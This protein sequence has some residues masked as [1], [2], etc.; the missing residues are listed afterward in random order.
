MSLIKAIKAQL[1]ISATASQNFTLTAEAADG[2]MKLARGNAG[3][4]TQDILAVTSAGAVKLPQNLV[5]FDAYSSV[6]QTVTTATPTK[7]TFNIEVY[8]TAS[9]FDNTTNHRFQP[10]VAGYYQISVRIRPSATTNFTSGNA[11]IYKNGSS[12]ARVCEFVEPN[13]V[14]ALSCG[15]I[16]GSMLVYL[17][18]S[19]DYIEI[20]GTV[21]GTGTCSFSVSG[22]TTGQFGTR[23]TGA[24]ILAA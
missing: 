20:Y 11:T 13:S 9:A 16:S 6:D 17:N 22:D 15:T 7:L 19:T 24:L 18:G 8:D 4:T 14:T 3:A 12:F 10:S 21:T 23:V 5:A 1:G 2:T